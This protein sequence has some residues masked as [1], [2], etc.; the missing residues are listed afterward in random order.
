M[1]LARPFLNV[2]QKGKL[3]SPSSLRYGVENSVQCNRCFST[4]VPNCVSHQNIDLCMECVGDIKVIVNG[5]TVLM[6]NNTTP[7][8]IVVSHIP[9]SS[10]VN[11]SV[12]RMNQDM[13][14]KEKMRKEL[15]GDEFVTGHRHSRTIFPNVDNGC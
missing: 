12:T 8:K 14:D 2:C 5:K 7:T 3:F 11:K 13:F 6:V 4:K 9:F 15:Y 10:S 1:A